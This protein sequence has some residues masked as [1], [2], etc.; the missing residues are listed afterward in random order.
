MPQNT[1]VWS[2][3]LLDNFN[4][5]ELYEILAMRIAVFVVEQNC[6]YQE[7][8][9]KKDFYSHHLAGYVHG[10]LVACAR[11]VPPGISY[12]EMSIGR[13]IT[14]PKHRGEGYGKALIAQALTELESLFGKHPVR[15][16]AQLYLQK[17]YEGF[18][19]EKVSDVYDEDGIPHIEMLRK[20]GK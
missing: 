11:L 3:K 12:E 19:F 8:D 15:I 5:R 13:V 4:S 16:S 9:G 2:C 14:S 20:A 1:I 6:V 17:F 7:L 10:E 18:G